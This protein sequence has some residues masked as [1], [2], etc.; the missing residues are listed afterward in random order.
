M[1]K[2]RVLC[3]A[4]LAAIFGFGSAAGAV[5][6]TEPEASELQAEPEASELQPEPEASELQAEPEASELQAEPAE[7]NVSA[8]PEATGEAMGEG[9]VVRSAFTTA[10]AEREPTDAVGELSNQMDRVL[11][12]TELHGLE[13]RTVVHRWLYRGEVMAEVPFQVGGPR[14]RVHSSKKLDSSWTGEWTVSV[15]AD[16]EVLSSDGF[17]YT[18]I[19][20]ENAGSE[21]ST[22]AA[23]ASVE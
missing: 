11:F 5:A 9:R 15:L 21:T 19:A 13:G 14:W 3:A 23:P 20:S 7:Q 10:I 1:T 4:A 18:E 12:F 17:T 22:P 6:Q 2:S 8:L 16:G